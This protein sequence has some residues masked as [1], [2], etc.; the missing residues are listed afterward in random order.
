[1]FLKE[2]PGNKPLP[3]GFE[4]SRTHPTQI[5]QRPFR[6]WPVN[7]L[8]ELDPRLSLQ[9]HGAHQAG[10]LNARNGAQILQDGVVESE[11]AQIRPVG[12]GREPDLRDRHLSRLESFILAKQIEQA[13][14]EKTRYQQE[15]GASKDLKANQPGAEPRSE[16]HTSELP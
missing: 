5:D 2:A 13:L 3:G 7:P 1:M 8:H 16:E 4:V 12:F 15:C 10:G 14:R 6:V 9:R 11:A